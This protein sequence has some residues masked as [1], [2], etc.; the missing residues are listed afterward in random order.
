MPLGSMN[1]FHV[2]LVTNF[3]GTMWGAELN[4]LQCI[5]ACCCKLSL[6]I[7]NNGLHA[8]SFA[9]RHF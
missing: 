7:V 8:F 6:K 9:L 2:L 5:Y 4:N 3:H 1:A